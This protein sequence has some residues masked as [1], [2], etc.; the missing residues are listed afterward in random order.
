ML[1]FSLFFCVNFFN[2]VLGEFTVE[3]LEL[4]NQNLILT[5][6]I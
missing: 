1:P 4:P 6:K 3:V 2:L 5:D